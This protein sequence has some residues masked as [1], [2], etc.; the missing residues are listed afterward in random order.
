M[1]KMRKSNPIQNETVRIDL[2]VGPGLYRRIKRC[3]DRNEKYVS[4][5]HFVRHAI[6]EALQ[7]EIEKT[8]STSFSPDIV[9]SSKS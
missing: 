9:P 1:T 3:V 4:I 5:S 2:H 8:D 7:Q 6:H